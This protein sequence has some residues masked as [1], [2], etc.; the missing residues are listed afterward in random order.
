M[1]EVGSLVLRLEKVTG[2]GVR[3]I[4]GP[5]LTTGAFADRMEWLVE[6]MFPGTGGSNPGLIAGIRIITNVSREARIFLRVKDF[7]D[8]S[9]YSHLTLLGRELQQGIRGG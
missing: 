8:E 9:A 1:F 4:F 5:A 7:S 2:L 6:P 3:S